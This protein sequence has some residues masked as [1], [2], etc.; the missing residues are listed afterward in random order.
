MTQN[1]KVCLLQT[2]DGICS[3]RR[4]GGHAK[5]QTLAAALPP[6]LIWLRLPC[7][8]W[9]SLVESHITAKLLGSRIKNKGDDR[10]LHSQLTPQSWQSLKYLSAFHVTLGFLRQFDPDHTLIPSHLRLGLLNGLWVFHLPMRVTCPTHLKLH[11]QQR[12]LPLRSCAVRMSSGYL[13][14][15]YGSLQTSGDSPSSSIS[16]PTLHSFSSGCSVVK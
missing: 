9:Q 16:T 3:G 2:W 1:A 7:L 15:G 6:H 10:Q 13:E 14:I 4:T 11:S 5:Q 12:K 8:G